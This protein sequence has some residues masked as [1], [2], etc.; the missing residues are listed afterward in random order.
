MKRRLCI[1]GC[2]AIIIVMASCTSEK[3]EKSEERSNTKIEKN[4][5]NE[6]SEEDTIFDHE[7][8]ENI[9]EGIFE[10]VPE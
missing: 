5:E 6:E 9:G 1:L 8:K 3:R 2:I 7:I 10:F 4:S